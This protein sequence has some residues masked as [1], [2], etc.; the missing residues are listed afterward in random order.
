MLGIAA[1]L[2]QL[3]GL[4]YTTLEHVYNS[5]TC[6]RA[7]AF[8]IDAHSGRKTAHTF[9]ECALAIGMVIDRLQ[10]GIGF[11]NR[12]D[13]GIFCV[14]IEKALFVS[15]RRTVA[16]GFGDNHRPEAQL[17]RIDGRGSDAAACRTAGDNQ[18]VCCKGEQPRHEIGSK[19][20][21]RIFFRNQNIRR[22][23]VQARI[24]L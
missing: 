9:P 13:V 21:G 15:R 3:P 16:D 11:V 18:R 6:I 10:I 20:A 17:A 7:L 19:K 22:C 12:H 5:W 1:D 4:R 8:Y 14:Q 23:A 24:G 2:P